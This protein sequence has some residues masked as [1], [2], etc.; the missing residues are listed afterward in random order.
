MTG[1]ELRDLLGITPDTDIIYFTID[2][3]GK[4]SIPI[5]SS[6]KNMTMFEF[7]TNAFQEITKKINEINKTN[8]TVM[9]DSFDSEGLKISI[10]GENVIKFN[11]TYLEITK[12][13]SEMLN[14]STKNS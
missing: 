13:L 14:N 12:N 4:Q 5:F 3:Q 2:M 8:Y 7:W 9:F 6:K 10:R 11:D 1:Q